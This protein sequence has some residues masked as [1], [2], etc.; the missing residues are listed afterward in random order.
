M[1]FST[2]THLQGDASASLGGAIKLG[3]EFKRNRIK[4]I[5]SRHL[6]T[7]FEAAPEVNSR[8]LVGYATLMFFAEVCYCNVVQLL[9]SS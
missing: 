8:T 5:Q 9:T 6:P 2:L 7:L 4:D 1:C 3:G